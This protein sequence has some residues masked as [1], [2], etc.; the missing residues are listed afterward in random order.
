MRRCIAT[1]CLSGTLDEKLKAIAATRFGGIEIFEND[2]INFNRTPSD[3][4]QLARELGLKIELFQPFR[5]LEGVPDDLFARNLDRAERKFDVMAELGAP[6]L[7]VCSNAQSHAL[8]DPER[9]AA[10]LF[11]LAERAAKRNIRIA[12]EALAWGTHVRTFAQ[13]WEIV[14]RAR[15]PH[16]GVALDSFHT[17]A[18]GDDPGPIADIP[19]DRIFFVQL[20]D[21]PKLAL[22]PL[23]WSRHFR[24]FPGQGQLDVPGFLHQVLRSGYTGPLS[25]EVFNDVFRAS[26]PRQTAA[27]AMRSLLYLEEQV[28]ARVRNEPSTG[29]SR[30]ELF[31]PPA[32]PPLHGIS[33]VEFAVDGSAGAELRH[34]LERLGFAYAGHH[35][36]KEVEL[37]R[38]GDINFVVNAQTDSFAENF[39][40]AHGPAVCAI[41]LQTD[42]EV[43]A[44]GRATA[45]L[46][47]SFDGRVGPNELTIPAVRSV[48]D[49]LIY[50]IGGG[51]DAPG[52]FEIDFSLTGVVDADSGVGLRR[53]DHLALALPADAV[54]AWILFYRSV[55]GLEPRGLQELVEP[56]GL[57]RSR[58]LVNDN[59]S[60]RIT[61]NA[62]EGRQTMM[63]RSLATYAGPG[64]HHIALA[65]DDIF[66]TVAQLHARG[67]GFLK[68][69]GNYF[70]DLEARL[71]LDAELVQRLRADG[72]MYDR[73]SSGEF[74][75]VPTESFA[76]RFSFEI[77][78]RSGG[79][80][81][82]GELNAP[83]Y[84]AAQASA[85]LV[86]RA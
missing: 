22:D 20:A 28:R 59:R 68:A 21:A 83:V 75:H 73:T 62:S 70:D 9:S 8:N 7:L 14:R 71:L 69:P 41:G 46:A 53:V 39:F 12:F 10:Q 17:L 1:V 76:G 18:L 33:F 79:Y 49:S 54:E 74:F 61:L 85:D 64:V 5:D 48:D 26:D 63:A 19:G 32:A 50:F 57:M 58:A 3:V 35:R 36:S 80:D 55:L 78:Q 86:V 67:V 51:P 43:Q 30:V 25:L 37:Y 72:I 84:L 34:A 13:V 16:L 27:D 52:P 56:H 60:L 15:H 38:Q 40:Q 65:C 24:N 31:D 77:V 23:S 45:M 11:E 81:G 29:G 4:G 47:P 6:M 66:A 82:H 42:D 44:V 2:L